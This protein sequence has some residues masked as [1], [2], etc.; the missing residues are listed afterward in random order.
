M[1]LLVNCANMTWKSEGVCGVHAIPA[2]LFLT[3]CIIS[4]EGHFKMKP[5]KVFRYFSGMHIYS[6]QLNTEIMDRM[7][8]EVKI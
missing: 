4:P 1:V 8:L 5:F 3:K 7:Q 2:Y 6:Q